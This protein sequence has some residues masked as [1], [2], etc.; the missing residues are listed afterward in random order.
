MKQILKNFIVIEGIDGAGTTTQSKLLAK[1]L[2]KEGK[3]VFLTQEPTDSEIG[4]L[5]RKVL[6]GKCEIDPRSLSLLFSS[7]R[8]EHLYGKGGVIEHMEN[9]FYVISDRYFQSS[10]AYQGLS[11]E[12]SFV[13]ETNPFPFPE[14]YIF[15]DV[16]VDMAL[17]R[18]GKRGGEK[19]IFEKKEILEKVRKNYISELGRIPT[20]TRLMRISGEKGI[21]ETHSE[22]LSLFTRVLCTS[23]PRS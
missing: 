16:E 8:A 15:L 12:K 23:H 5:I 1:F 10:I 6:S 11:V 19:E 4:K 7:D 18:I 17:E 3:K 21:E 22:I 2:E 9:G 13:I 20:E 14:Y